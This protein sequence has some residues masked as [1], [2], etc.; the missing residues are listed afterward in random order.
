VTAS[1]VKNKLTIQAPAGE[2]VIIL[3]REFNAPRELVFAMF[4]KPEHMKRWWG[5]RWIELSV[6][7]IDFR[8]G[9]S[10]RYVFGKP[11]GPPQTFRGQYHEIVAPERMVYTLIYDRPEFRDHPATVTVTFEEREGRTKLTET[12]RHENLAFRDAHLNS[13]GT[14][15]A[16]TY[17]RLEELLETMPRELVLTRTFNAPRDLVFKAWT[18]PQR[19]AQWFGFRGCTNP[20][21]EFDARPGGKIEIHM[22]GPDGTI[23]PMNGEVREVIPPER[24]VFMSSAP[25]PDGKPMFEL[26]NTIT[27][28]DRAG[29]TEMTAEIRAVRITANAAFALAGMTQGWQEMLDRLQAFL[30][31]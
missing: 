6:C 14:G 3:T 10:Y 19:L 17:D 8:P 11:G 24:L 31:S 4:T 5:P 16:E 7:E 12:V 21:C 15:A 27:L 26:L 30:A 13:M 9:G 22:R 1:I 18:D 28:I 25:G 20:V 23:Y 2:P 29:K